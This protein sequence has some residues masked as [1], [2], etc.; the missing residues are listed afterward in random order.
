MYQEEDLDVCSSCTVTVELLEAGALGSFSTQ[1]RLRCLELEARYTPDKRYILLS[2]VSIF[3]VV[4]SS[5][6]IADPDRAVLL[7]FLVTARYNVSSSG[8]GL[9]AHHMQEN[10][11]QTRPG[12]APLLSVVVWYRYLRPPLV[13]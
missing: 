7:A 5:K 2:K 10:R 12:L 3:W 11:K 6:R 13:A 8:V 1:C 4:L 9:R